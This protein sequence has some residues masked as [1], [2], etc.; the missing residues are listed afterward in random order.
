MRTIDIDRDTLDKAAREGFERPADAAFWDDRCYATHVPVMSWADR[1]DDILAESNFHVALAM[2]AATVAQDES[3]ASEER[4][5]D[6]YDGTSSHWLVGSLREIW[7]RV[8]VSDDWLDQEPDAREFTPVFIEA[9][10]IALALQDYPVLDESDHSD[11]EHAAWESNVDDA[12][13]QAERDHDDSEAER[14][15]FYHVLTVEESYRDRLWDDAG[16]PDPDWDR[17]AGLYREVRN[18]HFEFMAVRAYAEWRAWQEWAP[19][20]GQEPLPGV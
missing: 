19:M 7:V 18:E 20:L 13:H 3:G 5:D 17:V 12:I 8:Y 9:V 6:F 15:M 11:R 14:V 2:L 16:Y 10:S 1:G 4:G